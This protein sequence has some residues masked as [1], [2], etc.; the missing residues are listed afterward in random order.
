MKEKRNSGGKWDLDC[1]GPVGHERIFF[2]LESLFIFINLFILIGG[3]IVLRRGMIRFISY[4]DV[5]VE[6]CMECVLRKHKE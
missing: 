2:P 1:L 3:R 5:I 6:C 4:F